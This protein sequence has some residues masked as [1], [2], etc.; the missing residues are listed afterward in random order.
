MKFKRKTLMRKLLIKKNLTRR[1]SIGDFVLTFQSN[2][3]V[4]KKGFH[5]SW[6]KLAGTVTVLPGYGVTKKC[7]KLDCL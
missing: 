7:V 5:E 4:E 2:L 3:F 6:T 1:K